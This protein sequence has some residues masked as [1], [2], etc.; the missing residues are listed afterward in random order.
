MGS[1]TKVTATDVEKIK[2][3]PLLTRIFGKPLWNGDYMFRSVVYL[4]ND[5]AGRPSFDDF[6][7]RI[8]GGGV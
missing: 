4:R 6:Y 3:L 1:Y 7:K 5:V 8:S 2:S